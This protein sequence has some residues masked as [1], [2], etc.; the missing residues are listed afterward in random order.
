MIVI[1]GSE[2]EGG[3]Q[4]LR[5]ALSLSAITGEPFELKNVRALRAKPGLM[6]QHLTSVRA[7]AAICN[8]EVEGDEIGSLQLKFRPK[9]ITAGKYEF[10][11]GTAGSALLV[12][13]TVLPPLL[14]TSG[15][16]EL[17]VEGG[18]HNPSA[19]PFDFLERTY[20]PIL[21]RMGVHVEAELER[22]G[23]YP[24]G[25]G[26]A[27]VRIHPPSK[28]VGIELL[29]RGPILR[30][31]VVARVAKLAESIADRELRAACAILGWDANETE[32]QLLDPRFGPGNVMFVEIASQHV[33]EIFSGFGE[34]GVKAE[35]IA[36]R[37][38]RDAQ[39]YLASGAPVGEHLAD[40]LL[41]PFSI[42]GSGAF[43]TCSL[44][45]HTT[46]QIDTIRRFLTTT[47]IETRA[48]GHDQVEVRI[49]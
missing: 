23:F 12:L 7:A 19:P 18:T 44:T 39:R 47:K 26:R 22:P 33:T 45:T 6:R 28:L 16:S 14:S 10:A 17:L 37:A 42:A 36:E 35:A 43:K 5:S 21:A 15:T 24:A 4:I 13:Q 11:V 32:K 46:T 1:D 49:G 30:R 31:R 29:E 48:A 25:G 34:R 41:L 40:Q 8:A 20:L 27:R 2:G 9:A 38:A 3:G